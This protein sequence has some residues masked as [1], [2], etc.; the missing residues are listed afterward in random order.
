V[1][2]TLVVGRE[3]SAPQRRLLEAVVGVIEALC[4]AA[5]AGTP[6]AELARLK[7]RWLWQEGLAD[8]PEIP[9]GAACGH[10]LGLGFE[11]PFV[12]G[13]SEVLLEPGMVLALETSLADPA[14]GTAAYE[15][16]VLVTEDEPELLTRSCPARWW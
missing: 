10:G 1:Q 12:T 3:P 2:R 9:A 4:A 7:Q 15:D 6:V 16:V 8:V 13:E 14:I 5:R 11:H